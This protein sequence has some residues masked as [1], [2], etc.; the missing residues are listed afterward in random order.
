MYPLSKIRPGYQAINEWLFGLSW[1]WEYRGKPFFEEPFLVAVPWILRIPKFI[2]SHKRW[3]EMDTSI[4]KLGHIPPHGATSS[5]LF[6]WT[7]YEQ[8]FIYFYAHMVQTSGIF[9]DIFFSSCTWI[10]SQC[11]FGTNHTVQRRSTHVSASLAFTPTWC[12][13]T[14]FDHVTHMIFAHIG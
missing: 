5:L 12:N 11:I 3:G 10:F 9:S 4:K 14:W 7:P 8:N 13:V 6:F 1:G 2:E